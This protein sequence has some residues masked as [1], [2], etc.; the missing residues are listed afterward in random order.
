MSK[1]KS[2][3]FKTIIPYFLASIFIVA[4][5]FVGSINKGADDGGNLNIASL[6]TNNFEVS[7]GQLSEFYVVATLA[8]SM[9]LNSSE[10]LSYNYI[11]VQSSIATGQSS[12]EVIEKPTVIDTSNLS[13]DGIKVHIVSAGESMAS[14]AGV[15]GVTTDQIRWSNNRKNEDI[16]AGDTLYIPGVPGII[17]TVGSGDS[18]DSIIAKTGASRAESALL[19]DKET[20]PSVYAGEKLILVNG[21]LPEEERPEYVPPAPVYTYTY[22]YLGNTAERQNIEVIGWN[23]TLGGQCVGYAL[24]YRNESGRSSSPIPSTWGNANTWAMYA[25]RD[26]YR[27]DNT[28]EVGAIFQ[29]ASGW[30]GHVGVV[31]GVNNDGSIVVEETNY[32]Y[33]TGR[34]TRA[35]IPASAVGNFNYIH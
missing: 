18:F 25:A 15:Y 33:A 20:N 9:N 29:T 10:V 4:L 2:L 7:S 32:N 24:W 31:V 19:N 6:A 30:Y 35:T 28:P 34:V 16:G 5:A 23:W 8:D 26:G 13:R 17:Y 22:S 3:D 14:I 11:A 12:T 27:V 21:T 1:K